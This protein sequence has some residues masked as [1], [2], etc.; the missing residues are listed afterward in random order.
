MNLNRISNHTKCYKLLKDTKLDMRLTSRCTADE[1]IAGIEKLTNKEQIGTFTAFSFETQVLLFTNEPLMDRILTLFGDTCTIT[2]IEAVLTQLSVAEI[3]EMPMVQLIEA[4]SDDTLDIKHIATYIRY[5]QKLNLTGDNK[6]LLWK[7][8]SNCTQICPDSI[9][10]AKHYPYLFY[11]ETVASPLLSNITD[12]EKS[13]NAL[14]HDLG[15]LRICDLITRTLRG[16]QLN[17]DMFTQLS[18]KRNV[19]EPHIE[20][21]QNFFT[22][23]EFPRFLELLLNSASIVYDLENLKKKVESGKEQEAHQMVQ[24]RVSYIAFYHGKHFVEECGGRNHEELMLYAIA[25]NKKAF[26]F[27]VNE[28]ADLYR[29]IPDTSILFEPLFYTDVININTLNTKNLK[30]CMDLSRKKTE[31]LKLLAGSKRTF[32]E[33]A[34]LYSV[35]IIYSKVYTRLRVDSVD[36]RLKII[37]ELINADCLSAD[38]DATAIAA[39]LSE[40]PMSLWLQKEFTHISGITPEV[41]MQLLQHYVDI[42]HLLPSIS[43]VAEALYICNNTADLTE[44]NTIEAVHEI[45]LSHDKDWVSLKE[46]L[47]IDPTLIAENRSNVLKFICENGAYIVN[48]YR[49]H[50]SGKDNELSR[51]VSAELLGRFRD[52]KYFD[53]DLEEEISYPITASSKKHWKCNSQRETKS[54]L[55]YEEDAFLPVMQIG[56]LPTRSCLSYK[57][58]MYSQ[59]L[60][61]CHDSNKK[62][63]F[64]KLNGKVVLRAIIRLTKG[65][66]ITS[67]KAIENTLE[68]ADLTK[69]TH[70][71]ER[72]D[73][74]VLFLE[75]YYTAGLPAQMQEEALQLLLD[76]VKDKA[77]ALH[78]TLVCADVYSKYDESLTKLKWGIYISKSKAGTQYLDS[79]GGA[80]QLH[81]EGKYYTGNFLT[82]TY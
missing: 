25:N 60:L 61:A 37:R 81:N 32:N 16:V 35:P 40:K 47:H 15:L 21:A 66:E 19:V 45:M 6:S 17:D 78:A 41:C 24:N 4:T 23:E 34:T 8:L 64:L 38:S 57:D 30:Q 70:K 3:M 13:L 5:F 77:R 46:A 62:V 52:L 73:K 71:K 7:C 79:L 80:A 74:L 22:T 82:N 55:V 59:C 75:K 69:S 20:W 26:L 53:G 76:L 51:L 48:A 28:K 36:E 31:C 9:K 58:G 11:S 44:C 49:A 68:F 65:I 10:L 72:K 63:I 54:I 12:Y 14:S 18:K 33:V 1:L 42:Q 50:Q 43:N 56:M 27:L 67:G 29:S 39:K 2:S